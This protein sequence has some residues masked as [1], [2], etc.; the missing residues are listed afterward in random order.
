MATTTTKVRKSTTT[1]TKVRKTRKA[2]TAP[3]KEMPEVDM[4]KL[5]TEALNAPGQMSK[6]YSRFYQYSFTNMLW[7]MMQGVMEPVGPYGF[8]KSKMGRQVRRGE[9]ANTVLHP[10]IIGKK[11]EAG[12]PVLDKNGKQVRIVIGFKPKAS[13][14]G[15]S[16]TDG[17]EIEWPE[18]PDWDLALALETLGIEQ[19]SY[20]DLDGN[21]QGYSIERKFAINP[22]AVHPWKTTFHELAHIVLGHTTK[23]G[24]AEYKTHRGIMEFQAEA[25]AYLL[26]HEVELTDW[27]ASESRAYIQGW[28]KGSGQADD[29]TDKHIRAVFG[30]VNKILVA[31]RPAR[32]T[33]DE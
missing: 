4:H 8:W 5:I 10:I 30:A 7:L 32:K 14:F 31:G 28:L 2:A 16:Q 26:A 22:T 3:R 6:T 27:N 9:K 24:A 25:V 21:S 19:V 1:A 18:I 12:N 20:K 15:Y 29:V 17:D 33:E 11:D 23:D 13:V